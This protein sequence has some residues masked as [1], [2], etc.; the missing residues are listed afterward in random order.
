MYNIG[1]LVVT[2]S[3]SELGVVTAHV[4]GLKRYVVYWF[5]SKNYNSVNEKHLKFYKA[6]YNYSCVKHR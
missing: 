1:D 3:C 5:I 6:E 2:N 4:E